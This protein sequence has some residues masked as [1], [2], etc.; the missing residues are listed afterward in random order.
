[1]TD[2]P[3]TAV[4]EAFRALEACDW[5]AL[6]AVLDPGAI[7]EFKT[8]QRE[9]LALHDAMLAELGRLDGDGSPE[10]RPLSFGS[11]LK[12]VF[13]VPDLPAFEAL[14]P[15][16]V[17]RRWLVVSRRGAGASDLP[18]REVLGEVFEGRDLAHVVFRE[19]RVIDAPIR[20]QESIRV[21]TARRVAQGWRTELG[22]GLLFGEDGSFGIG[23]DPG[24]VDP[25]E[26]EL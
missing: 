10:E 2:T 20:P 25:T 12:S 13:A 7:A 5:A 23:Y 11:M 16:L 18:A 8:R 17:L 1:M 3:R 14:P 22:G 4:I 19:R 9:Q 26:G 6:L 15:A 24:E 21:L